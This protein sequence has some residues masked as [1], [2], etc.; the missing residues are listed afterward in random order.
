MNIKISDFIKEIIRTHYS[1]L[2]AMSVINLI[3]VLEVTHVKRN[4]KSDKIVNV[5]FSGSVLE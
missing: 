5:V 4:L 3:L 1:V 2:T